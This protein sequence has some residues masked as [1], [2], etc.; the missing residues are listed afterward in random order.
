MPVVTTMRIVVPEDTLSL[1][2]IDQAVFETMR[3]SWIL[4]NLPDCNLHQRAIRFND[5]SMHDQLSLW[6]R[7][8]LTPY[9]KR[10]QGSLF[11]SRLEENLSFRELNSPYSSLVTRYSFASRF[12]PGGKV[13]LYSAARHWRLCPPVAPL[14]YHA[15]QGVILAS[16]SPQKKAAKVNR[17]VTW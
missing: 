15:P 13:L 17:A 3:L 2:D 7:G 12:V 1:D 8:Y 16:Q 10:E 4:C 14:P 11:R 9:M 6:H 5:P